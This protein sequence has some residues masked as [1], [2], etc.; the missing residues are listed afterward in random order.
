MNFTFKASSAAALT[1][2]WLSRAG[3]PAAAVSIKYRIDCDTTGQPVRGVTDLAPGIELEL[4][5]SD[6]AILGDGTKNE[7][8]RI[9]FLASWG[10]EDQITEEVFYVV[11]P[12]KHRI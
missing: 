10:G 3:Q 9:T 5:P 1:L 11:K 12:L 8:R 2:V 7:V 6:T 4:S